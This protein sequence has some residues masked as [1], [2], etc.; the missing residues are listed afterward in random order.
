MI[1]PTTDC[2]QCERCAGALPPR[3]DPLAACPYCGH[4]QRL[5][6]IVAKVETHRR[7]LHA[8]RHAARAEHR[9]GMAWGQW[10]DPRMRRMTKIL[11]LGTTAAS[12]LFFVITFVG[13]VANEAG[14]LGTSELAES[15]M[16]LVVVAMVAVPVV[17]GIASA[18]LTGNTGAGKANVGGPPVAGP[19][20]VACPSCG[21]VGKLYPGAGVDPCERCGAA[22]VPSRT[23]M[24]YQLDAARHA[25]RV[26]RLQRL[27]LER[28]GAVGLQKMRSPTLLHVMIATSVLVP[29]VFGLIAVLGS[30]TD[31]DDV[32]AAVIMAVVVVAG[33]GGLVGWLWHRRAKARAWRAAMLELARRFHGQLLPS[34]EQR[35]D[36]LNQLWMAEIPPR[37]IHQC[38]LG[39]AA[40]VDAHGYPALVIVDP[41][42]SVEGNAARVEVLLAAWIPGLSDAEPGASTLLPSPT[43]I[44]AW[45]WIA[46]R[47]FEIRPTEGGVRA[48][49]HAATVSMLRRNPAALCDLVPIIGALAYV[50]RSVCA[51]PVAAIE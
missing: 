21:A 43:G 11:V 35:V 17:A 22:L 40:A 4:R 14:W 7:Q 28:R 27:R 10:T 5:E 39:C 34:L 45:R 51:I 38:T 49:A 24:T 8:H 23:V 1:P 36:W 42:A 47:G 33:A 12:L 18:V 48:V 20:L 41:V 3:L 30:P 37:D 13:M 25:H 6:T 29:A 19:T 15:V 32:N 26:A 50:A 16:S 31:D 46:A 9:Q 44:E 2:L